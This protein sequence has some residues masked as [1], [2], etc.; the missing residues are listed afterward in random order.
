MS[1]KKM[2]GGVVGGMKPS[3][4]NHIQHNNN[5]FKVINRR[6]ERLEEIAREGV[7][8]SLQCQRLHPDAILPAKSGELEAGWDI[9]CVADE[10]FT[11]D[12]S[13]ILPVGCSHKFHTGLA[14]AIDF[15]YCMLLWDRSGMGAVKNIHRLA[16]VIDCTYRG[17]WLVALINLGKEAQLIKAGDKIIQGI[18]TKV[19]PGQSY[20][21]DE[22]SNSVRGQAGFGEFSGR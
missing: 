2:G 21:A 18:I 11:D 17:E 4:A 15:G 19:I 14:C 16:G 5:N 22:L 9:C 10:Y 8:V 12:G 1:L 13:Y 3:L 7:E 20:W 6:L